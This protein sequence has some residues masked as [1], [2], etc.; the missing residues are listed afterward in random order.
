MK[1]KSDFR[2]RKISVGLMTSILYNMM[3]H[4]MARD[5]FLKPLL[6]SFFVTTRCNLRCSYCRVI[7][8]PVKELSTAD[9]FRILEKI[10]PGN[11]A[12]SITGGEPTV[13]K[14]IVPIL[15]MVRK[16]NFKPIF[17]N[18]NALTL[19]RMEPILDLVD[20][21]IISLDSLDQPKWDGILGVKN[22]SSTIIGNIVKYAGYQKARGF[23]MIINPVITAYN[24]EDIYGIIDF[25]KQIGVLVSPV[26][27]DDWKKPEANLVHNPHYH[28]LIHD[29]LEFKSNGGKHIVVTSQFLRQVSHFTRHN[30][31]PTLVPRVYPDGSV[32]YPCTPL[33]KVYGNLLDYPSLNTLLKEAFHKEG[34]P[35]CALSSEM[36]FMS[37]FME[38]A[39]MIANP[40][41][42]LAEQMKSIR[43]NH[44]PNAHS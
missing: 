18:T 32:F 6:P 35:G 39:N 22:A 31:L 1:K 43:L 38:P 20:Y 21:L 7:K 8:V 15:R 24:I 42:M 33:E 40:L 12:L 19:H 27:E 5:R 30:C 16:L 36:C 10:R 13:R 2:F 9:T 44:D 25:C 28:K 3:L 41:N 23:R 14:D 29:L 26:P 34:L 17:F 37:C 4:K 11:Q